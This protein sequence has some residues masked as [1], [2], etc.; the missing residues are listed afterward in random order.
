MDLKRIT[1]WL[2]TANGMGTAVVALLGI[3]ASIWG[4][5]TRELGSLGLPVLVS[6]AGAFLI[7]VA[8]GW[9]LWRS[10]RRFAQAS[11]LEYPDAF[12]LRPTDPASLIGRNE[13]LERLIKAVKYNRLV[14]LDGESGCGKS[15]LVSAGLVPQLQ[16]SDGLL[17]LLIRDWGE[18]WVRGPLSAVL[19]ALFHS[20][21]EADRDRLGWILPPDLAADTS[22][23]AADLDARLKAVFDTLGRRP[24]LIADQF[25][26]YQALHRLRFLDGDANWLTPTALAGANRFW[27]LVSTGLSEGRLH[28][29]AVT[30]ADTAAGLA[31]VRFL[32]EDQT[33]IRTLSRVEVEYLRPLLVGIAADGAQPEVVSNPASGWHELR[34]RLEVDLKA[35][36]AILMQQVRTVLLGLRRLPLLTVRCYRAAGGL[37]GVETLVISR[38]LRR[39]NEAV[40]GGEVGLRT[41]RAVLGALVL[42]GGPN[43][44]PKAQRVLLSTLSDIVGDQTRTKAILRVLQDDE[45]V[46]PAEAVA[47][48]NAWQLDHDYLAQAVLAEARQADRWSV[49][50]REGKA[51]YDDAAGSWRQRWAALLPMGMLVRVCWERVRRRLNFGETAGYARVS[52]LKPVIAVLCL[53]LIGSVAYT[54]NQERLRTAEA[55]RLVD[56]LGGSGEGDAVLQIWRAPEPLRRRVY[57]LVLADEARIERAVH[58]PWPLAHAGLEPA[59]AREAA[60][61]LRGWLEHVSDSNTASR[62][63]STYAAVAVRL[64]N[65]EDVK[66]VV[67]ILRERLKQAQG[68]YDA[69][70]LARSYAIVAARLDSAED[71]KEAVRG[72]RARLE[73]V[74]DPG[75]A[76]S[77][78]RSY[79]IVAARLDSAEDVK[80]EV[81]SLRVLLE[82]TQDIYIASFFAGAYAAVAAQLESAE[83]VKEAVR[84]LRGWL[85]QAPDGDTTSRFAE[86]YA[87]VAARLDSAEDVKIEVRVLREWLEQAQ[88]SDTVN[89]FV[90]GYAAI[91]ARLDSVEDVKGGMIRLLRVWLEHAGDPYDASRFAGAYAAVVVWLGSAEDVTPVWPF[92]VRQTIGGYRSRCVDLK[93]KPFFPLRPEVTARGR[94]NKPD[95]RLRATVFGARL[96][97]CPDIAGGSDPGAG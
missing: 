64:D 71:V 23:L 44:S 88:D 7:I 28:L 34:E 86:A 73:Q 36:G 58:T 45:I 90:G 82:Q 85:E 80:E 91:V 74:R 39:V 17:P 30:R 14:L 31:C 19:E 52:A 20:M 3:L 77:L 42:P 56:R 66:E 24:L 51:R 92:W 35:E 13:D 72:L 22:I 41:A 97:A 38:A 68:P 2:L 15:A 49:A 40:S 81:K 59:G 27:E 53:A 5:V 84:F 50:L 47:D 79:A 11:R 10:F 78:A 12:T 57:D 96:V 54:L 69:S 48:G 18:D 29:L 26:D 25:D 76:S 8:L 62:L 6:R 4:V 55:M 83:N 33:V 46:R 37:H 32:G 16:P 75:I 60:K 61:V 21:S 95:V 1:E 67:R 70:N 93:N 89:H 9:M 94:Y 65:A 43:Q 63:A 87:A